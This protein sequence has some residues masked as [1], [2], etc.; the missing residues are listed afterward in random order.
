MITE[1][2]KIEMPKW[3]ADNEFH[4]SIQDVIKDSLY[5]PSCGIDGIPIQCFMG[6]I[7]SFIYV[8]YGITESKFIKEI[9]K[10][11]SIKGY[12]IIHKENITKYQLDNGERIYYA[13]KISDR[14]PLDGWIKEPYCYWIIFE[15]DENYDDTHNPKRFSLLY[16]SSEA[17]SAYYVLYNR[18]NIAPKILCI[19]QDG[20][21][22]GGNWTSY[23]DRRQDLAQAVFLN[24]NLPEYLI[25]GGYGNRYEEQDP[26]WPEYRKKVY[27][28]YFPRVKIEDEW[29]DKSFTLWGKS[30]K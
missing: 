15:R 16:L 28:K 13:P 30:T 1:I 5:Y 14:I 29:G 3:L 22:F 21:G 12:N 10:D 4:F 20:S 19:I 8:D 27:S 17:V 9:T 6:N 24:K 18:N 2:P 25:N 23:K 7:F 11:N 26:I